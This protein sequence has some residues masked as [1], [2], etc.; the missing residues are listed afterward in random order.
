MGIELFWDNDEQTVLLCEF[1]G[2][3]TWDDMHRTV[4]TIKKITDETDREIAAIV[5]VRQGV[6]APG[7]SFFTPQGLDNAKEL[8]KSAD[9]GTGPIVIVGVNPIFKSLY[10]A[11]SKMNPRATANIHFADTMKQAR[12]WLAQRDFAVELAS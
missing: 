5:D 9:K 6:S 4:K 3:W 2:K 12:Q 8:L 10:E 11:A 7:G 1:D